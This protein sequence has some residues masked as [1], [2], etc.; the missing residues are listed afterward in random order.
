MFIH[1]FKNQLKILL[2]NRSM[3]FWTLVFPLILGTFF[4][5][6]LSDLASSENFKVIDIA[7]IENEKLEENLYFK[8]FI[9]ELSKENE[10]QMFNTKYLTEEDAKKELKE[11]KIEGYYMVEDQ[12]KIVVKQSGLTQSI[13]KA[14]SDGY[15][16][17]QSVI[18]NIYIN[19]SNIENI[20]VDKIIEEINQ[21][22]SHFK[23]NSTDKV[24]Y[25]VIYF[26]TLIGMSCLY[27]GTFGINA[28]MNT[29]ANL[30]KKAARI[31]MSPIHKLKVLFANICAN[32]IVQYVEILILLAFLVFVLGISFGDGII[33]IILVT[34]CGS[35]AGLSLGILVGTS[36][37]KSENTKTG[38]L[39]SVTMLL[40]F[41][42]G[43][44]IVSMKYIIQE[45]V[46]I[47]AYI[48]PVNMITDA[49][50]V[51]YYYDT[52]ERFWFNIGSL[53]VFSIITISISYIFI[54]RKKY[55]SI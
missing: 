43:M 13:M 3:I 41:L 16:Q 29:E 15:Y 33:Y 40:S 1:I 49:L 14:V 50:Y 11:D 28:V 22:E 31:T 37:R 24:D 47:L 5:M 44:M 26:Y 42:S 53:L 25:S 34:L 39:I 19:S 12:I 55:D 2:R 23:D 20:N 6:A 30:S 54:R 10:D 32:F 27:A 45:N 4:N 7:I 51:L 18:E 21:S 9:D 8:N 35:L 17:T 38:I 46:P 36:N 52:L 48:N